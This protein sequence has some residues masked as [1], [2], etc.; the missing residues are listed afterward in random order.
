MEVSSSHQLNVFVICVLAGIVSSMFFDCLRCLRKVHFPNKMLL[1]FEDFIFFLFISF[2]IIYAGFRFNDGLIR[3]YQLLGMVFGML[4]Y[5]LLMSRIVIKIIEFTGKIVYKY[6]I[7]NIQRIISFFVRILLKVKRWIMAKIKLIRK[8]T[9][10][11]K[12]I[13]KRLKKRLKML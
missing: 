11:S 8:K 1:L 10:I 9:K 4:L 5:S 13:V 2:V 7:K 12:T 3:Y 6:I